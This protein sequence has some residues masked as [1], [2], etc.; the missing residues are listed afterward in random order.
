M[1]KGISHC[2]PVVVIAE[3]L[4]GATIVC[5]GPARTQNPAPPSGATPASTD[6]QLAGMEK[7][8]FDLVNHDRQDPAYS[9]E[10]G[11]KALP[12][13]WNEK[14]AAVARAHSRNMV[15]KGYFDHTDP[16]GTTF[17]ARIAATGIRWLAMAENIANN[18]TVIAAEKV[19][20]S[21]PPF[22]PNHRANILDVRST[23]IGIGIVRG[24]NGTLYIT[25]DF[26][27][28]RPAPSGGGSAP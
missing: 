12:L 26:V 21:E 18:Q 28:A 20:M 5:S 9:A 8:M 25:Q 3:L 23:D 10:T 1:M 19:F 27:A 6:A 15:E 2:Q 16:D 7:H 14:L 13:K 4:W 24:P 17:W 11:G 22:K